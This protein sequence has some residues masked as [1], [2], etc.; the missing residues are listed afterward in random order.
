MARTDATAVGG[1][2]EVDATID[3][4]PFIEAANALVTDVCGDSG[5]SD[6]RLELIERW[7]SAHFYAVRDIRPASETAGA[8]SQSFQFSVGRYLEVTMYGQQA[9]LLDVEGG[10]A[11]LNAR[12][13]KGVRFPPITVG[14]AGTENWG[15]PEAEG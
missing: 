4:T 6:D 3:V 7:L 14:W 11:D 13:K 1:I 5:Y 8:V 12:M 15:Q 2:I 9:M 10:L